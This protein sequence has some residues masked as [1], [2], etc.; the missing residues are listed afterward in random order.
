MIRIAI[1]KR[2]IVMNNDFN[3]YYAAVES[4]ILNN[5]N[6]YFSA[7]SKNNT[8][9]LRRDGETEPPEPP[10]SLPLL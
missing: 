2:M 9:P 5:K 8:C 6:N 4:C 7:L 1:N 10:G 3:H